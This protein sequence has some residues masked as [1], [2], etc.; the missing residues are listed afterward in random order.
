MAM[1]VRSA[2][3]AAGALVAGAS[4][5]AACDRSPQNADGATA[6]GDVG[7]A[8]ATQNGTLADTGQ[9]NAGAQV[10][11]SGEMGTAQSIGG[12]TSPDGMAPSAG[13]PAA[14]STAATPAPK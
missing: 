10:G 3:L 1:K 6:P 5:L 11:A 12:A 4:L 14:G 2:V 8:A 9:D 7:N 13:A